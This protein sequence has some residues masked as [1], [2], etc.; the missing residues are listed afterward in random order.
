[1]C[2]TIIKMQG[3]MIMKKNILTPLSL[4][5]MILIF[6][7]IGSAKAA[8]LDIVPNNQSILLGDTVNIDLNISGLG[9]L[10]A[11]SL[12]AFDLNINFDSSILSFNNAVYGNQLDLFGFGTVNGST[13]GMG[14]VN[15]F[16]LSFDSIS[17]L[18]TLQVDSFTL[19]TLAFDTL[20]TG[21]S[22]LEI[23]NVI[24]S[25][26]SGSALP[27]VVNNG[28]ASVVPVPAALFL[29]S[30][31]FLMLLWRRQDGR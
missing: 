31:G 14:S 6:L 7:G 19:V 11:D 3:N 17:D 8:I 18:N 23:A 29:F 27:F 13:P 21:T 5:A 2:N 20:T 25:D 4:I 10:S 12:G 16:E 22:P 15:L 24:L 1:M 30:T 26:A 9:D 28:T